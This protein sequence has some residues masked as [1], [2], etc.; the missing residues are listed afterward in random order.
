MLQTC[1]N[2]K[3]PVLFTSDSCP[4][5]LKRSRPEDRLEFEGTRERGRALENDCE[6]IPY[7]TKSSPVVGAVVAILFAAGAVAVLKDWPFWGLVCGLLAL[8]LSLMPVTTVYAGGKIQRTWY[9][10]NLVR[11]WQTI[12]EANTFSEVQLVLRDATNKYD[13]SDDPYRYRWS[14]ELI[15]KTGKSIL[16]YSNLTWKKDDPGPEARRLHGRLSLLM[17]LPRTES[18]KAE[19]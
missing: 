4:N 16:I 9:F 6:T 11:G 5:C 7:Q 12:Y 18:N 15:R 13:S 3:L 17:G 10:L 14:V 19:R 8:R 2:C 1:P